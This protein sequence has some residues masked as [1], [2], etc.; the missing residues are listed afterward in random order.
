MHLVAIIIAAA[1]ALLGLIPLVRQSARQPLIW[2][3]V[4]LGLFAFP[5][6]QWVSRTIW[7]PV[8]VTFG[9]LELGVGA[10]LALLVWA[11]LAEIFK[12]APVLVVASVTES[13]GEEWLAYGAATGAG[14]GLF[15]AQ[16][17]IGLALAA[18]NL[19]YS[20]P[21]STGVAVVLRIF[22]ILAHIATA[23]FVAW[24]AARGRLFSALVVAVLVQ[25]ALGLVERGHGALGTTFGAVLSALIA[26]LVFIYVWGVRD[27]E[28]AQTS[29][30]QP[31]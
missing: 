23:A 16:L 2:I 4:I 11:L 24:S 5:I 25:T 29:P 6:T 21:L 15:G 22:P 18:S 3:L 14:F 28:P 9:I 13:P 17:V 31:E 7:E 30:L 8:A 12:L 19:P 20:T 27:R 1:F 26:V 10:I